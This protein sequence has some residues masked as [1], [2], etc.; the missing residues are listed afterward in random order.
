MTMTDPVPADILAPRR[1]FDPDDR[2]VFGGDSLA[3]LQE[4]QNDLQWLLDRGYAKA[5]ALTLSVAI[6]S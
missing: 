2:Q 1:G 5:G 3:R 6:I 4:A